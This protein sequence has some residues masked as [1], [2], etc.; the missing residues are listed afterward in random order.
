MVAI[1]G[2]ARMLGL[3]LLMSCVSVP[4]LAE[5]LRFKADLLPVAGTGST[6]SGNVIA[7]FDTGSKKL[8]WSG[9]YKGVGT[10]ATSASFHG[11]PDGPRRGFV[12]IQTIDSPFEGSAILSDK[13]G[14][15][16]A[17]G[18]WSIVIRTAGFPKG[19]LRG[20]LVRGN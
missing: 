16:L 6:A 11:A 2:R 7:D 12:K 17:A 13:Q 19:E 20:Q 8:T 14:E 4:A 3:A 18:E 1:A 10:Y 5:T 9:S 15:G